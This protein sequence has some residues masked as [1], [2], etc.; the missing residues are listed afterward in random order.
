VGAWS[1]PARLMAAFS[2]T[3][4][5]VVKLLLLAILNGFAV[6]AAEILATKNKW[7]PLVVLAVALVAIDLLYLARRRALPAKFL[8]PGTVFLI[9]FVVIPIIY[10]VTTAFTNYSTGHILSKN[11][12]IDG[13][14]V[15]SLSP[16][17]NGQTYNLSPALDKSGKLVLLLVNSDTGK[18]YVGTREGLKPLARSSVTISPDEAITGA[19]GYTLITGPKLFQLDAV[20]SAYRVPLPGGSAIHP[21][22][23]D[24]AVQLVPT[25]KY[26]PKKDTFTEF[27]T[28]LVYR[29]NG[30]GSFIAANGKEL[31]PGWKTY[32]GFKN[33][34]RIIHDPLI[35]NPFLRVLLWTVAFALLTV[36]LSFAL[37][38][39]LAVTLQKKFRLQRFYRIVLILPYA[40]PAFLTILVWAGLFNDDFGIINHVFHIHVPWL[41]D[42]W[43]ARVSI[44]VVSVWLTFPYFFLVSLGALQ[45]IPG[46]LVEAARVDGAGGWQVFRKVTLPLLLVAV[47]PLM[48]ASFAF[49]FNNFN[50]I[51]LLTQGGPP[52]G[53]QP[54]AGSTDIL[55]SYTYKLAFASGKGS[56]Y[57]LAA[58]VSIVIFFIVATI[59]GIAFW[60]SRTLETLR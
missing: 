43:W 53:D 9:A 46:E 32:V 34:S 2:G 36:V 52:A 13:I 30:K 60:R 47:A 3:P 14:K 23:I 17:P 40:I 59:S 16:P 38:L 44:I 18:P 27:K 19:A 50:V 11:Q 12:A 49:N 8:V 10:T 25:L 39:F 57:A 51:Y 31:E 1:S 37:G 42:A 29:D 58:A 55:I 6:W 33:F 4:G 22:G 28:G 45:S 5:L 56:D 20:L 24:N 48:I 7:I 15:N 26:D 41:F 35:R 21:E 54:I